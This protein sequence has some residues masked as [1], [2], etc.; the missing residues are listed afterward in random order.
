VNFNCIDQY[1]RRYEKFTTHHFGLPQPSRLTVGNSST[2]RIRLPRKAA[3]FSVVAAEAM[4][5]CES[6]DSPGRAASLWL[7]ASHLLSQQGNQYDDRNN[8]TW[9]ALRLAALHGV[10]QQVDKTAAEQG[11]SREA[12]LSMYAPPLPLSV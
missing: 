12:N 11:M 9:V 2:N 10:S 5:N 7:A 6:E 1:Y 3:F 8:Y 4:S